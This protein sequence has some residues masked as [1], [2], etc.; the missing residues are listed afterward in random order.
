MEEE[1]KGKV[2]LVGAGPGDAGLF[3]LKGKAVLDQADVVVYDKLV[4]Q[5]VLGMIPTAAELIFVGKVSG[6][7]PVPQQEINQILLR[8]ALAGKRVVRLKG[9]DP[10]VFGRGGEELELLREH[11]IS[12]EI[13]PGITSAVSVPAYNGIPVT[14]RDFVSS[15]HIITGHTKKKDE[16]EIDYEALVKLGGTFVFLMGISAMPKICQGLLNAGMEADMPAAVL[17]RGTSAHQRRVVSDVSHLPEEAAKAG[18]QTPAIIVVGKVCALEKEF[19]WAEDRPLGG[20]KIALTRPQDRPSSLADKLSMLGAEILLMPTIETKEIADNQLLEEAIADIRR[21]DY[22][23]FTSPVGVAGFFKKL[24]EMKKDIRD[25]GNVQFAAI[26]SATKAAIEKMGILVDLMPSVY[27]GEALG[28]LLADRAA[29]WGAK[30]GKKPEI[31]IPRAKIGTDEVLRPLKEAEIRFTDIPV[32]DTVEVLER[33]QDAHGKL[34]DFASADVDYVAFTSAS[35]VRGF[36]SS[37]GLTDLTGIKAVCIGE[38]TAEEAAK[39]GMELFV[40][41]AATIDSMVECF[42]GLEQA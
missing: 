37:C 15:L 13:V 38:K 31:L 36:V 5:G 41:R 25:L 6:H 19:H 17:E 2:W 4:G 22:V 40:A 18:I 35:T 34:I 30:V 32:Y 28:Q 7:H 42:L 24:R 8:E 1:K 9:G 12:F 21:F 23:A 39:Y 33:E 20:L 10:F 14:H 16:A 27:S 29:L 3:T 11:G 26:G